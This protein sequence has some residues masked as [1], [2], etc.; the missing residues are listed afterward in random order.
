MNRLD[1]YDLPSSR[2]GLDQIA[3]PVP[4]RGDSPNIS[5]G[6]VEIMK[7]KRSDKPKLLLM[8]SYRTRLDPRG[9]LL[10]FVRD[11]AHVLKK[12]EI[13]ATE[14]TYHSILATG[15]YTRDEVKGHRSGP[16]GGVVELAAMVARRDCEVFIF[17]SDPMDRV[18]DVPENRALQRLCKELNVRL[19]NTLAGAEQWALYEAEL[20]IE[21]WLARDPEPPGEIVGEKESNIDE[22]GEPNYLGIKQQT[23]ALIS[24]D[25]KKDEM[26]AFVNKHHEFLKS[27]ERILTTGTTGYLLKLLFADGRHRKSI[28]RDAQ[29]ALKKS[30]PGRFEKL[31]M[32]VW[33]TRLLFCSQ[34]KKPQLEQRAGGN[35]RGGMRDLEGKLREREEK[36]DSSHDSGRPELTGPD[37]EFVD[38]IMPL[39][40]G[41]KGGDILIAE[42]V[43]NNHCHAVVFFQDPGT[44][45][46]HEP[47]I[48]LFERTCQFWPKDNV[49]SDTVGQPERQ[50]ADMVE[51]GKVRQT[52]ATCVSDFQSADKWAKHMKDAVL[53]PNYP[54]AP[55]AYTLR[56]KYGLRDVVIVEAKNDKDSPEL[57]RALARACAG[58]L[59]RCILATDRE[60]KK[61]R[62]GIG[63]GWTLV[64]LLNQLKQLRKERLLRKTP[65]KGEVI[66][67]TLVGNL[68]FVFTEQEASV[69]V[70]GFKEHYGGGSIELFQ[71]SNVIEKASIKKTLPKEDLELI[72]NLSSADLIVE[73]GA[74]WNAQATFAGLLNPAAIPKFSPN[75]VGTISVVFLNKKGEE[76][77]VRYSAVGLGYRGLQKAASRGAVILMCGGEARREVALA[78]LRGKLVSV[79]VTTSETAKYLLEKN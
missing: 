12:F 4:T 79:L 23:L 24:H 65:L 17:L 67:S 35:F 2:P 27:F 21:E 39:A 74:P 29:K 48:R 78:A 38:L 22:H 15:L 14:G 57:G 47:D 76:V 11:H 52:Y 16:E 43:L 64:E 42:E 49:E 36:W 46:P 3:A 54:L 45:Q 13:H 26:V 30:S 72:K 8:A 69:I 7:E 40:S 60:G 62:I 75:N 1:P 6:N 56:Q 63:H 44:A 71:A 37:Q 5:L 77:R 53:S 66:W 51:K 9:P 68:P 33:L 10:R 25:A 55:I 19:I 28:E 50:T 70:K 18:S 41:P 34:E 59:H 32:D 31:Q 58:Y 61:T 20:S 73:S